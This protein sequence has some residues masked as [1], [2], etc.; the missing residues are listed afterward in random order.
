MPSSWQRI[1]AAPRHPDAAFDRKERSAQAP[2]KG[3]GWRMLRLILAATLGAML[4]GALGATAQV[5]SAPPA[6]PPPQMAPRTAKER[7]SDKASDEQRVDDCKVPAARRTRPRPSAC[8]W[9][10]GS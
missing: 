2:A 10:A 7:L 9:D 8:P 4:G 1:A 5:P 6:Q 3:A